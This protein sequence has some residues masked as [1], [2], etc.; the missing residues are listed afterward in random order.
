MS[1]SVSRACCR[2]YWSMLAACMS[3]CNAPVHVV[4]VQKVVI[5][6]KKPDKEYPDY[7][8]VH[9]VER[10]SAVKLVEE[11]EASESPRQLEFPKE[12]GNMLQVLFVMCSL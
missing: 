8:F 12:S 6:N 7:G 11:C 9:F 4:Q 1:V 2:P 3:A 10:A 5:P